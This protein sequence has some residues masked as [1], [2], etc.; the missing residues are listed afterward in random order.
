[1][2]T[3]ADVHRLALALPGVVAAE[4]HGQRHY[5]VDGKSI[6]WDYLAREKPK[7]PRVRQPGIMAIRC[8]LPEKEMLVE[9]APEIYFDDDHYRDFPGVLVRLAAIEEAELKARL[10]RAWEIQAPKRRKG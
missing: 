2:A 6:A 4:K 10:A 3:E 9:A 5:A 1:M 8:P 7:T